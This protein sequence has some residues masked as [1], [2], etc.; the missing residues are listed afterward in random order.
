M[1]RQTRQVPGRLHGNRV[2]V[3]DM[4]QCE[5]RS[6]LVDSWSLVGNSLLLKFNFFFFSKFYFM[7]IDVLPACM[8]V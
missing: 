7:C 1:E 3:A 6:G 8:S 4:S 5:R 2:S